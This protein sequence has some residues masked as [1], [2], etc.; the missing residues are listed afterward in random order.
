[1]KRLL[2]SFF[3]TFFF[4]NLSSAQ[5]TVI[6][7]SKN[8]FIEWNLG[9]AFIPEMDNLPMPGTSVLWGRTFIYPNNFIFEY[10]GGLAFPT[11]ITG[12]IGIGKKFNNTNITIGVRPFPFHLYAQST[13][14]AG[15]KGY[16]ISSVE[17][18]PLNSND[19]LFGSKAILNF[20][21]RWNLTLGE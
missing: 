13:F 10:E 11:I 8:S 14:P 19:S 15:K 16:W 6:G 2:L 21:Y 3:C 5:E 9:I 20:G 18:N 17:F 4:L 1:M 12:K 7:I